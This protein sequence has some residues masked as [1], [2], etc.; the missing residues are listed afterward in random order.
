MRLLVEHVLVMGIPL[1]ILKAIVAVA[2]VPVAALMEGCRPWSNEGFQHDLMNQRRAASGAAEIHRE[3]SAP[4]PVEL[5]RSPSAEKA[6]LATDSSTTPHA[7]VVAD[8]VARK[9]WH[10]TNFDPFRFRECWQ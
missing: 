4:V 6:R 1:Q 2:T 10:V 7:A 9:P 8:G 3:I 5:Q